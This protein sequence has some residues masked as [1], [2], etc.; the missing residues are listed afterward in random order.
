M[1]LQIAQ[2]GNSLV[3]RLPMECTRVA[4]AC[5]CNPKYMQTGSEN[6]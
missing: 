6:G 4:C 5:L 3:V 2:W 1:K